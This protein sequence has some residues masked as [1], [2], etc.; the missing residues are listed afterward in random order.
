[1]SPKVTPTGV[2]DSS[3]FLNYDIRL[4]CF[5]GFVDNFGVR[6]FFSLGEY[7]FLNS[8]LKTKRI[9]CYKKTSHNKSF[10]FLNLNWS[11]SLAGI[12]YMKRSNR[13][14]SQKIKRL[15]NS[16]FSTPFR[17]DSSPETNLAFQHILRTLSQLATES[18]RC[19]SASQGHFE[20]CLKTS[21]PDFISTLLLICY[22][23]PTVSYDH[24]VLQILLS[25]IHCEL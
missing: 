6:F 22:T 4:S 8:A 19:L 23:S 13:L 25:K 1:M 11:C 10:L 14:L 15:F 16:Q 12:I 24:S 9:W 20:H 3:F 7:A 21:N 18:F 5:L 17:C 2:N